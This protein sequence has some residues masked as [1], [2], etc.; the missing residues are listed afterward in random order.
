MTNF[1]RLQSMTVDE[2]AEWLD[3]YGQFDKSPWS[4]WFGE[5]YC[6]KCAPIKCKYKDAEETLGFTPYLFGSYNGDLDCAYCELE[7]KCRFFPELDDIPDNL[8]TIK[9]WL[10]KE[11]K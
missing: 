1:E 11:T 8:E 3:K 2:L 7:N 6:D 4:T 5:T 10:M 9:M